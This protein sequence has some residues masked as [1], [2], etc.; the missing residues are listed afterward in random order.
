MAALN[1][2][3]SKNKLNGIIIFKQAK[4]C[5]KKLIE[6]QKEIKIVKR[7]ILKEHC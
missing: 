3:V 7:N 4:K 2:Y 1:E 6:L 5:L